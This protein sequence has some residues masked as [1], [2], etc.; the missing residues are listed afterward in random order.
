MLRHEGG[1]ADATWQ[2]LGRE[3]KERVEKAFTTEPKAS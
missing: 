1:K 2:E 3:R